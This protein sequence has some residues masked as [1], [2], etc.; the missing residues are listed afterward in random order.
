MESAIQVQIRDK[1]VCTN[2]LEKGMNPSLLPSQPWVSGWADWGSLA[3]NLLKRK[4]WIQTSR[5]LLKNWPCVASCPNLTSKTGICVI[6]ALLSVTE[7]GTKVTL[8]GGCSHNITL[9]SALKFSLHSVKE[10]RN[11][12]K[13]NLTLFTTH[14]S[15]W[16]SY[17]TRS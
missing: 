11:S 7:L 14:V 5:I 17:K 9:T 4:F 8:E 6:D 12:A 10:R 13:W 2:P 3:T 16:T 15:C 1:A